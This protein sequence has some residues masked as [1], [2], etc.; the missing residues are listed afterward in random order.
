MS[1]SQESGG[2]EPFISSHK[3]PDHTRPWRTHT[4]T[5]EAASARVSGMPSNRGRFPRPA[6][7]VKWHGG[8]SS[9]FVGSSILILSS[10]AAST[11]AMNCGKRIQ[12][13]R[14]KPG[15]T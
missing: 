8:A 1:T 13:S 3:E 4:V 5:M 14:Q 10:F 11:L 15:D 6:L 7:R 9:H 2:R 12:A